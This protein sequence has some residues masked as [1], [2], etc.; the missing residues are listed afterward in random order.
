MAARACAT[1]PLNTSTCVAA[2]ACSSVDAR[3]CVPF[4]PAALPLSRRL[5]VSGGS[6][7]S[8]FKLGNPINDHRRF[9]VDA[10]YPPVCLHVRGIANRSFMRRVPDVLSQAFAWVTTPADT[11]GIACSS[12][13]LP[14]GT[15]A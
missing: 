1:L 7:I 5:A 9:T 8:C 14:L 4:G 10:T 13:P 12:K 15:R 6:S 2:T 3:G 11:R